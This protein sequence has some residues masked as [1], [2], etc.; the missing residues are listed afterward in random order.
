MATIESN[1]MRRAHRV[2]VPLTIVI[3]KQAYRAKNWSMTG[4]GIEDFVPDMEIGETID[5]S[6]VLAMQ[7]AKLEISVTLELKVKREDSSG[8][9]FIK[10][11][12]KNKRILREFLELSIEGRL[13]QT[14]ALISIYNEPIVDTP[15][16]ESIV[17]SD[18]E[19]STLKQLFKKGLN[20]TYN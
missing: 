4:A 18:A 14:D 17:L 11:S 6:I 10:L 7:D 12:E 1:Q 13:D 2:T 15:I 20:F 9:E 8:F 19:E 5:A 16:T 3:N